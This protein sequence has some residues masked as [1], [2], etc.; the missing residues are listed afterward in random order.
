MAKVIAYIADN[1]IENANI[2]ILT[3]DDSYESVSPENQNLDYK[4]LKSNR[5]S[6]IQI[7][8]GIRTL[9]TEVTKSLLATEGSLLTL[10]LDT[11]LS[12]TLKD[13]F[14][15][16][17]TPTSCEKYSGTSTGA[18]SALQ[19]YADGK[20]VFGESFFESGKIL[21]RTISPTYIAA[22]ISDYFIQS[23]DRNLG[24]YG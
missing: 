19:G 1:H 12:N 11:P 3:D 15:E 24:G 13:I 23:D 21:E 22:G 14:K 20:K 7:G 17:N 6:L 5:I 9:K 18:L 16:K 4:K 10:A 2:V 8:E